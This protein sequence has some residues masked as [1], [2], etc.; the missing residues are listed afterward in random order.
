[1]VQYAYVI[2]QK[3]MFRKIISNLPFHPGLSHQLTFYARRLH[4]EE[5]MRRLG[6]IFTVLALGVQML[7]I[8]SPAQTSLATSTNDIVYGA[9]TKQQIVSAISSGQD[10][11]GRADIRQI[12]D[13]YGITLSD[14]QASQST[15]VRSRERNYITTGRGDSP[16]VD[17]PVQI[18]GTGTTIYERS[19][20]VWD[21]KNYE[22][23]YPA[24]TGVATGNGLLKGQRFWILLK[25]CGNI[26][27]EPVAKNPGLEL[28]KRQIGSGKY[29]VGEVF[30]YKI[31]FRNPGNAPTLNPTIT[32]ELSPDFEFVEQSS[33]L[34]NYFGQDGRKLVWF[35][36]D[37]QPSQN[38][39]YILL[40]VRIRATDQP[41]RRTC[42]IV[43]AESKNTAPVTNSNPEE[44]RCVTIDN[45][46]PG[47]TLPIPNGD[48]SQCV[49]TC[50]N[51][52]VLPYNQLD[53]CQ[54]PIASCEYLKITDRPQWDTRVFE[55][56][57]VLSQGASLS[58]VQLVVNGKVV[59]DFGT[60]NNTNVFTHT[61]KIDTEGPFN[62]K[63]V[64]QPARGTSYSE[65]K[66][67]EVDDSVTKPYTRISLSKG[68]ANLT[69]SIEDA[70]GTVAKGGDELKYTL[71]IS[72]SGNEPATNYIVDSDSLN[73][74]LEYADLT[75]YEGA[76]FDRTNQRLTW[77]AA[78]IPASGTI[79]KTFQVKVKSPIPSTPPSLS[80]PLSF[81]YKLRNIYGNEVIVS[82]DKPI[83]GATYQTVT[84]LPNTGPGSTILISFFGV[85]IIGYFYARS[86]LLSKEVAIVRSELN[87]GVD[88]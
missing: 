16:G 64:A 75:V 74:I 48:V 47:T 73:D 81:D 8:L 30:N 3:I 82:L 59:K 86:R 79:V 50:P 20:N 34:P 83:A 63:I 2:E 72:N 25:G 46:C 11:Y 6:A 70:N 5:S 62:A 32:D 56:K 38:W 23:Y 53:K 35:F 9:T 49:I 45:N 22:N 14:V 28:V 60:V 18:P 76:S 24:I 19:L 69:Q 43:N 80:D 4:Q 41:T 66:S 7:M 65:S 68:V 1:M 42:N 13:Y 58:K 21:I 39:Q 77:P 37:L 71:S 33:S 36:G 85:M 88:Q 44:E 67:C 15:Q 17:T 57:V 54:A 29:K 87:A 84:S 78:T 12:Y 27:F 26:T 55:S 31:E 10:T 51:G 52:E 40:K 61:Q